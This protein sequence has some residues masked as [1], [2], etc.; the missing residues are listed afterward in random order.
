MFPGLQWCD[1]C[2]ALT[3]TLN[4]SRLRAMTMSSA[5]NPETRVIEVHNLARVEGEGSLHLQIRGDRVTEV[6]LGIFEPPRFFEAFLRDRSFEEVPDITA[7]ICGICPVAYQMSAC[8]AIETAF[9]IK[10]DGMIRNL[11]RL[12]Y[13]GEWIESHVLHMFFLHLP[14]FLG[15]ESAI[16]MASEYRDLVSGAL[17]LK[18]A[19]NEI[20]RVLGGREVHPINV[21]VG[22]FHRVPGRGELDALGE[23]LA[24]NRQFLVDSLRFLASLNY[25]QLEMDYDFVALR[26]PSEVAML[27]GRIATSRGLEIPVNQ[28]TDHFTEVQVPHSTALH[29]HL[30]DGG[31]YLVGPLA[32]LNL[33]WD[34]YPQAIKGFAEEIGFSIPCKN[35]FKSLI[36]RGIETLY[37]VDHAIELIKSYEPPA[38][39]AVEVK[40][41]AGIGHGCTEAP[42]GIL[43]HRYEIG[44]DG[45]VKSATIIPPTAQNQPQ[46]EA[47]LAAYAPRLLSLPQEEMTLRCEQLIRNYDPCISCATHFL[48]ITVEKD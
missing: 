27:D 17:K 11:R 18:K 45:L 48:R 16:S 46:I 24:A 35:Q 30:R 28:F 40:V 47:D 32:R 7:R 15:Y 12:L 9:N 10:V 29:G 36:A 26:N 42:R 19:G 4:L 25:P 1:Y 21:R 6:K 31:T 13:C 34:I 41:R 2:E 39:P 23:E 22:G 44:P 3:A 14:D 20:L 38:E 43:Y 33:N 5:S 8:M 37:A